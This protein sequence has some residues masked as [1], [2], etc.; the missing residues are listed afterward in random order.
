MTYLA[1]VHNGFREFTNGKHPVL[2]P[3]DVTGLKIR[4]QS[5]EIYFKFWRAFD[6]DPVAM[7]LSEASTAIQQGIE[8]VEVA[9]K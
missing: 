2:T 4:V 7:S 5:G 9:R 3:E 8:N 6:G 1:S